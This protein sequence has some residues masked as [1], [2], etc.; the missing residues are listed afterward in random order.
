MSS[1]SVTTQTSSS[2]ADT[3]FEDGV[4]VQPLHQGKIRK[5]WAKKILQQYSSQ[6]QRYGPLLTSYRGNYASPTDNIMSPCTKKLQAHK[7]R[8]YNKYILHAFNLG[9][10]TSLDPS[11]N[12]WR[13]H[14]TQLQPQILRSWKAMRRTL[15][16]LPPNRTRD[17]LFE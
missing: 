13:A 16:Q 10:L 2:S 4:A 17:I 12:S 11:H 5:P 15:P 6:F 7:K 14:S 3:S 1:S 8:H 9:L